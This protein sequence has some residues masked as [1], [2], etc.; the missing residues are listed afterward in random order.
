MVSSVKLK[1]VNWHERHLSANDNQMNNGYNSRLE[2]WRNAASGRDYQNVTIDLNIYG[3]GGGDFGGA[4][5]LDEYT[6]DGNRAYYYGYIME[7]SAR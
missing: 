5:T 6:I 2:V 4:R 1:G 3:V 7:Y